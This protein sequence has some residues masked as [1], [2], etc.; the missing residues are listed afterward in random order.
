MAQQQQNQQIQPM[1]GQHRQYRKNH[2]RKNV[3]NRDKIATENGIL[4]MAHNHQP[5]SSSHNQTQNP[6]PTI[7]GMIASSMPI[8]PNLPG[9]P[10]LIRPV[11]MA[12]NI[13]T[14]QLNPAAVHLMLQFLTA[15]NQQQQQLIPFP[16]GQTTPICLPKLSRPS[17]NFSVG[18]MERIESSTTIID[19]EI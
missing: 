11:H 6:S 16:A 12:E 5:Q 7:M 17:S 9:L 10:S 14:Q 18:K 1:D 8:H 4:A 19:K 2:N 15:H 13:F 3:E